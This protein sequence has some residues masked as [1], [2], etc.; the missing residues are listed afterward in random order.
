MT[1]SLM[2]TLNTD[3]IVYMVEKP[4][5]C[6]LCGNFFSKAYFEEAVKIL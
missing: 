3:Y 2:G 1:I 6:D 4:F 5:K